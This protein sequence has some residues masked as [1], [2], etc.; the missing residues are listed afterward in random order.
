[1]TEAMQT[2]QTADG[3][4]V[5]LVKKPGFHQTVAALSTAFG[6]ET[7]AFELAGKHYDIPSGTAHFFEHKLFDKKEGDALN[8]FNA[9]GADANAF[10]SQQQ[11]TY[12]FTATSRVAENLAWLLTFVQT[13][14]F[15]ADKVARER[16]IIAQEIDLYR[17]DPAFALYQGALG[18]LYPGSAQADDIAGDRASLAEITAEL[19]TVLHQVFYQPR[20][21]VLTVV[22]NFDEAAVRKVIAQTQASLSRPAQDYDLLPE[23][24]A[25]IEESVQALSLPVQNSKAIFSIRLDPL[26]DIQ[27]AALIQQALAGELALDLLFGEQSDWYQT[28]YEAGILTDEFDYEYCVEPNY[29]YYLFFVAGEALSAAKAAITARLQEAMVVLAGDQA[30]LTLL[31]QAAAG[32]QLMIGDQLERIAVD[33]DLVLYGYS[34]FDKM[35][36]LA[37]LSQQAVLAAGA[38]MF[39][40]PAVNQIQIQK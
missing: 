8:R 22:G 21:L 17:D 30:E 3:L 33:A 14:Y 27:P 1:M 38:K 34:Y 32:E 26:E 23:P 4:T 7:R 36:T 16:P 12:Y 6:A 28:Q 18:Q 9:L 35:K 40:S 10:T 11:T 29:H 13:P 15:T 20:Q 24:L 25:A 19:L 37:S 31:Q 2:Y 5:H 39:S